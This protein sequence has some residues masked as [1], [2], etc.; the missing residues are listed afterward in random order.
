MSSSKIRI[1]LVVRPAAGGIRSHLA[2]LLKSFDPA[3]YRFTLFAPAYFADF[4]AQA[5]VTHVPLAIAPRNAFLQDIGAIHSLAQH[6]HENFNFVHAHGVRGAWVG[7]QAAARVNLPCLFTA[8]NL[9]PRLGLPSRFGLNYAAHR[10]CK[11]IAVS[12]AVSGSLQQN[13]IG[14]EK[15]IVIPNGVELTPFDAPFDAAAFRAGLEI[16]PQ[17]V[18]L[19]VAVGRLA[20]EK[21]FDV[22]L[23]ALP[24]VQEKISSARL[25]LVG[26]GP[27]REDLTALAAENPAIIFAG[28]Q[29]E[30]VSFLRSADV[31]AIPSRQEGQG[32][33]ALEAMA[34]RKPIVAS[35]VGGLEE[36]IVENE[37]GLLVPPDNSAELAAALVS[38]LH[39]SERRTKMGAAGRRRVEQNYTASNMALQTAA[40]YE[41]IILP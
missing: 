40:L 41:R 15:I 6:L 28:F 34:A 13:G 24:L 31:V 25:I 11:I 17:N 27:E 5:G 18:P 4:A 8:H 26:N 35:R 1:A 20:P 37:T 14:K 9:V 12:G 7:A 23:R 21:G 30:V 38:L 29:T 33:V 2:T 10:C 3:R 36:M 19:I 22:L 16:T 39:D 32:I